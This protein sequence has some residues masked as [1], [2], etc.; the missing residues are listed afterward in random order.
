MPLF[1][2]WYG[3]RGL[4]TTREQAA[5][6]SSVGVQQGDLDGTLLYCLGA[7]DLLEL[8]MNQFDVRAARGGAS[9]QLPHT[10]LLP[11]PPLS[12]VAQAAG[13]AQ[14]ARPVAAA[15]VMAAAAAA[16]RFQTQ[17]G[18]PAA[19]LCALTTYGGMLR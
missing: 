16:S 1:L 6:F 8:L 14:L 10:W 17:A 3:R 13:A 18:P 7:A 2:R 4:L 11:P 12:R 19:G 5:F 9:G 15:T